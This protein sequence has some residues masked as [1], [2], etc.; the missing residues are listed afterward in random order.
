[1][2]I[3]DA[4]HDH[5][6]AHSG[7]A[8]LIGGR[9]SYDA[10]LQGTQKPYVVA[11]NVSDVKEHLHDGQSSLEWPTYQF[12]VYAETRAGAKAV[13]EQIKAA[14]TVDGMPYSGNMGG[15]NVQRVVLLNELR[16]SYRDADGKNAYST[17]DLEYQ[18]FYDKE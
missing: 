12:T 13:A 16:S 1:M 11:V 10:A 7:L 15:I 5:L 17:N 8:A 14:F 3:E 18:I 4:L 9:F 2:D 6:L